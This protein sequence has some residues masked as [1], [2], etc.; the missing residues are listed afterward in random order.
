MNSYKKYFIDILSCLVVIFLI[1]PVGNAAGGEGFT[2][3]E[4]SAGSL[5]FEWTSPGLQWQDVQTEVGN[6]ALPQMEDL[7]LVYTDGLPILPVDAQTFDLPG[8]DFEIVLLDTTFSSVKVDRICPAP[9]LVPDASGDNYLTVY[10]ENS[11]VYGAPAFYPA[12][13]L[14]SQVGFFRGKKMLRIAINPIRYNPVSGVARHLRYLKAMIQFGGSAEAQL[15]GRQK[16]ATS[17]DKLYPV[18][19]AQPSIVAAVPSAFS[20]GNDWYDP[21]FP[22]I[23][24]YLV[25]DGVY[26]ISGGQ[27]E[28]L[29]VNIGAIDP[30][31][32]QLFHKGIEQ[33]IQVMSDNPNA[34]DRSDKVLFWG[35]RLSGENEY[36]FSYSD[37]NVYWLTWGRSKGKRYQETSSISADGLEQDTFVRT[38]HLE[39]DL[40]Y[41][42]GDSDLDIHETMDVPGEGWVWVQFILPGSVVRVPFDLPGLFLSEDSLGV[43]LRLRGATLAPQSPDH[44]ARFLLNG[45]TI[46]DFYFDDREEKIVSLKA[47]VSLAKSADNSFEIHSIDDLAA[48]RS[49]FY[50]DWI[51]FTYRSSLSAQNGWLRFSPEKHG[52]PAS[53]FV[54]G[55]ASDSIFGWD[56]VGQRSLA[57]LSTSK[58]WK[59]FIEVKSAG[60]LDG[61]YAHFL[62]NGEYVFFGKRGINVVTLDANTGAVLQTES[63]D[64][65]LSASEA[66]SLARFLN[67]IADSTL[68]LAAVRDEGSGQLNEAVFTAFENL[69]STKIREL[70]IRDSW[71][72]MAR[73]QGSSAAIMEELRPSTT[74]P[75]YLSENM[76]FAEGGETFAAVFADSTTGS[77]NYV[78]FELPAAKNPS[79]LALDSYAHLASAN[80]SADY[81]IITHKAFKQQA[82]RLSDYRSSH[83]GLRC[84]VVLVEDIYDEFSYGIKDPV[85]IRDFLKYAYTYWSRPQ[86][87]YVLLFGDASWD[88]KRNLPN[89]TMIDF[90]PTMGNPVSDLLFVCFDGEDDI[91]PEMSVGRLPVQT[92][93]QAESIVDKIIE[94]EST[95]SAGWK[96]NFL[97]IT[98]GF[99]SFEQT[100]FIEQSKNLADNFVKIPPTSGRALFINKASTGYQEGENREEILGALNDGAVWVN[101]IG[102]AGSRTW[103]LMFNNADVKELR[104]GPR[105]PFISSMTCHTG[106]FAEPDQ[107]SFGENF[108]LA[109]DVGAIGF[110]GTAGWGYSHEDYLFLRKL[111]PVVLQDTV[112]TLGDAISLAKIKLWETYGANPHIRDLVLQYNLLGDPYVNLTLPD[113][114]DLAIRPLDMKVTP[115]VPSEADSFATVDVRIEN[116]GLSTNDSVRVTLYASSAKRE[117]QLIGLAYT[118]AAVGLEDSVSFSWPLRDWA[119]Q[120]ELE[121]VIDEAGEIKEFDESNNRGTL[122]VNVLSSRVE[123]LAPADNAILPADRLS[124]KVQNPQ[125]LNGQD[126]Y[127]EFR[128]DT[129][130]TFDS[131][132]LKSSG[133]VKNGELATSWSVAGLESERNYFWSSRLYG[134]D[135]DAA[136]NRGSFYLSA[137]G[138]YGWQ[139]NRAEQFASDKFMDTQ[140]NDHSITLRE[141]P[142]DI[143]IES[144]GY[145]DGNY[146][147]IFIEGKPQIISSRGHNMVVVNYM[148]GE[149]FSSRTFDTYADSNAANEL[150][151]FID[152]IP[153]SFW[154]FG[155]IKDEG[156]G[157]MN[158]KGYQAMEM[159]GS[160]RC[161]EVG[162]RDS[163]AIMGWKGASIG[164]VPEAVVKS[165][166]GVATLRDTLFYFER[167][168]VVSSG[169]I[170]P[171]TKWFSF[172]QQSDLPEKTQISTSIIGYDRT[173]GRADTL[174]RDIAANTKTDLQI[175]ARHYPYLSLA[176]AF[177]TADRRTSARMGAWRVL[178]SPAPDFAIGT[179]VFSPFADSVLVGENIPLIFKLYNLGQATGD[180]VL[181]RFEESD[182]IA[183][184]REF[185]SQ[186]LN[187][188]ISADGFVMV[189]TTWPSAGKQGLRQL[190]I[191]VDPD[192][193]HAEMSETNNSV[194]LAVFVKS[195]SSQP[196]ISV[197]FDDMEI[198]DGDLVAAQPR[199]VARITDNSPQPISDSSHVHVFLDG[200]KVPFGETDRE[201]KVRSHS[202]PQ[203]ESVIEF[204][205]TLSDGDHRLE[206][207]VSD[208]SDNSVSKAIDFRVVSE[209]ELRNVLNYPNPFQKETDFTYILTQEANVSIKVFTVAGRLIKAFPEQW[210]KPGFNTVHWDG[211]DEDGDVP[212]NG[213]YLYKIIAKNEKKTA[214]SVS[215]LIIMR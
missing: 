63:F 105:Y 38:I 211:R 178:Y 181:L 5:L 74:G 136:W 146:A 152:S 135:S 32:L 65:Y 172:G 8:G 195:D 125:S 198:I 137:D 37:T 134:D 192:N 155:A 199:I 46:G 19:P 145:N 39:K 13:Y 36:F 174:V 12:R 66:D 184:R 73:K 53:F 206:Y 207:L 194:S 72:F 88:P 143:F 44:H 50:F 25:D 93:E 123:I 204:T 21:S 130:A 154:V 171:A 33:P 148:T 185:G 29:G 95:A 97:F 109:E 68:L 213:V 129:L 131:P 173:T 191:T 153:D 158:E 49:Q 10:R 78:A 168:G 150:Y 75:V 188:S 51:E 3:L 157:R 23:K 34:M 102:H 15:P 60:Y 165:K 98:G 96:K 11:S 87:R 120:V 212:A 79:R 16:N 138:D 160:A 141:H 82:T 140:I 30:S 14:D 24:I 180:S 128:L 107:E 161:R 9:S 210:M 118:G 42:H 113:E 124:L 115:L 197:T 55:F 176:A 201:L 1:T 106:R 27:L 56:T 47:P 67:E 41:Y 6:Y 208:P 190:F 18:S 101:F 164:S 108:L 104:N 114:P 64:T 83:N 4:K 90:V 40:D 167:E 76:I 26:S 156:S 103:D 80:N 62:I 2:V 139:Q 22:Y 69:G 170:G 169:K 45:Q 20:G 175:N 186:L 48:D 100:V 58:K 121:A 182:P 84:Q 70:G 61:N 94:Y 187:Q 189:E 151:A 71:A 209:L 91:L 159:I 162:A 132:F 214:E 52:A 112:H 179:N 147:R 193:D 59:A 35:D 111:F 116:F 86:P 215:K 126:F 119:G 89:A 85:A 110:W 142:L 149:T 31:S 99:D 7:S 200:Q 183:G 166:S 57:P 54:N 127:L 163:W 43:R 77:S 203:V 28:N 205:P 81:I 144:A 117:R 17:K 196:C 202:S 133:A 177:A 92:E 122:K